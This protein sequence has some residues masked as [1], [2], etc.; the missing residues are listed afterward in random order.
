VNVK[1]DEALQFI[2]EQDKVMCEKAQKHSLTELKTEFNKRMS[3][4]DT[5]FKFA[6]ASLKIN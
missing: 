2:A 6:T 3:H 4:L 5:E 1:L